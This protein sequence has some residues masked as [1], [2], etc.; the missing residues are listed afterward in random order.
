ML[1]LDE[2]RIHGGELRQHGLEEGG[3]REHLVGKIFKMFESGE[4]GHL[5]L[6]WV[7]P[8]VADNIIIEPVRLLQLEEDPIRRP[9]LR[10]GKVQYESRVDVLEGTSNSS[11]AKDA[12][13]GTAGA[14]G[15]GGGGAAAW[16]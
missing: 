13:P 12:G 15:A 6:V 8:T 9:E 5:G 2:L 14:G 7:L 16:A 11:D 4:A 10:V 1:V 3:E